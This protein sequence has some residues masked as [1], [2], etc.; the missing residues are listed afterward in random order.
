MGYWSCL[1]IFSFPAVQVSGGEQ[2]C[3]GGGV[4]APPWTPGASPGEPEAGTRG[5]VALWPQ[6]SRLAGRM[7][8][9]F[10]DT[11]QRERETWLI[12]AFHLKDQIF[13]CS[14][15]LIKVCHTW[16]SNWETKGNMFLQAK[17]VCSASFWTEGLSDVFRGWF[18]WDLYCADLDDVKGTS[19]AVLSLTNHVTVCL[20]CL[21]R[22]TW[23]R[24]LVCLDN[25]R[26]CC[27]KWDFLV[28]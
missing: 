28:S 4:G 12:L 26:N 22:R 11:L 9:F 21:Q 20:L 15:I 17:D 8:Y 3:S 19:V 5:E 27:A 13:F 14:N 1:T 16:Y 7:T 18:M 6:N 24:L 2:D 10:L 25:W 23:T